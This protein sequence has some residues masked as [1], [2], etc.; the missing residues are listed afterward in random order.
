MGRVLQQGCLIADKPALISTRQPERI[1]HWGGWS[2]RDATVNDNVPIPY[3]HPIASQRTLP[4]FTESQTIDLNSVIGR[5]RVH[6]DANA[7]W[8]SRNTSETSERRLSII[9]LSSRCREASA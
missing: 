8:G 2:L 4:C 7:F 9:W 1:H 5:E 3:S 6:C